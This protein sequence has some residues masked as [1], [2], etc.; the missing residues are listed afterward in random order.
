MKNPYVKAA[1]QTVAFLLYIVIFTL[2]YIFLGESLGS[3][4][5]QG[6]FYTVLAVIAVAVLYSINLAR[7]RYNIKD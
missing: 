5:A 6:I 1:L 2:G 4:T 3:E 7:A